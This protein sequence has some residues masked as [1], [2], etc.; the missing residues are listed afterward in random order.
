MA[1]MMLL[2]VDDLNMGVATL[3]SSSSIQCDLLGLVP[4]FGVAG[5]PGRGEGKYIFVVSVFEDE[6]GLG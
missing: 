2:M 6:T 5:V 3:S 4:R 1:A